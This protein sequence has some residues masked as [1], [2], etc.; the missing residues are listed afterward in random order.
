MKKLTITISELIQKTTCQFDNVDHEKLVNVY[1]NGSIDLYGTGENICE[2]C[3]DANE[4]TQWKPQFEKLLAE[5]NE[6]ETVSIDDPRNY[7]SVDDFKTDG[8]FLA[9]M[10]IWYHQNNWILPRNESFTEYYHNNKLGAN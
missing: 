3:Q 7:F 1:E 2:K 4:L 6:P 8:D 9:S 10:A 5:E